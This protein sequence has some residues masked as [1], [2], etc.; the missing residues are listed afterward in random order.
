MSDG[1]FA[2]SVG[3]GGGTCGFSSSTAS[4]S[5]DYGKSFGV[6]LT[7][8]GFG[9]AGGTVAQVTVSNSGQI[10]TSG[11]AASGIFAQSVG[12][13]GGSGGSSTASA[14]GTIGVGGGVGGFGAGAGAGG[15]V[16]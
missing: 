14:D 10:V 8:G 1:I 2:Q 7:L 9:G 3:G 4:G 11:F 15:N 6:A 16:Q 5:N 12:G 13:G